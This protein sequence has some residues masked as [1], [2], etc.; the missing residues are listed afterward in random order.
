MEN[1]RAYG[2]IVKTPGV[3]GGKSRIDGTR[4]CVQDVAIAYVKEGQSPQEICDDF[5]ARLTLGQV[6][7]AL[8]Y[9]FDH[10]DEIEQEIAEGIDLTEEHR[11]K[12]PEQCR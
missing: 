12:H 7:A 4:L 6:H 2:W 8:A 10:R 1:Q 11:D 9:Y 3:R 5:G